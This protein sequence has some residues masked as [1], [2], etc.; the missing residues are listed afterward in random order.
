[1]NLFDMIDVTLSHP[2]KA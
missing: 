2:G 1:M